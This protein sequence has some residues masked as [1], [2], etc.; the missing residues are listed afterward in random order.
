MVT[1]P[2]KATTKKHKKKHQPNKVN[3]LTQIH[4]F[5]IYFKE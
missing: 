2:K 3:D 5:V 4:F 1:P